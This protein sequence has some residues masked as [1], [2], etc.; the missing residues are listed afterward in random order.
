MKWISSYFIKNCWQ[1]EI[2]Y[3]M[4]SLLLFTF[5]KLS[6]ILSPSIC[7]HRSAFMATICYSSPIWTIFLDIV[8][9]L[10][11]LIHVKFREDILPNKKVFHCWVSSLHIYRQTY[12]T[13]S[14]QFVTLII[15]ICIYTDVSFQVL[16]TLW[17]T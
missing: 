5:L 16:Q 4:N 14:T 7:L 11:T 1:A 6:L 3:K 10:W 13:K 12:M 8:P 15:Y 2:V 9:L 17:Q